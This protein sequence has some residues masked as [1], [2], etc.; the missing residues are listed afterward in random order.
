MNGSNNR[1]PSS[2]VNGATSRN[3]PS[4]STFRTTS[5]PPSSTASNNYSTIVRPNTKQTPQTQINNS[6]NNMNNDPAPT[7]S[8]PTSNYDSFQ[9]VLPPS[10]QQPTIGTTTSAT[11]TTATTTTATSTTAAATVSRSHVNNHNNGNMHRNNNNNN[12][13]SDGRNLNNSSSN[14]NNNNSSSNSN[15]NNN[16]FKALYLLKTNNG[17]PAQVVPGKLYTLDDDPLH[18]LYD[19]QNPAPSNQRQP[20]FN[21]SFQPSN[22]FT[23]I[24]NPATV[25]YA[26]TTQGYIPQSVPMTSNVSSNGVQPFD[27]GN[28]IKRVQQDYLREIQP[29]VSSVK[30]VEKDRE[31]GQGLADVGF[32]TPVTVRKGF[33][34]QADDI[35]RR[36][37]GRQDRARPTMN[38]D[39][40]DD[41]NTYSDT[42][43]D[44]DDISDLHPRN[45]NKKLQKY[46]SKQSFTSVTS[47]S[48]NGID[49]DEIYS[50]ENNGNKKVQGHNQATSPP[51]MNTKNI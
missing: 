50:D 39:D 30:F 36:S 23:T 8:R 6:N 32:T 21:T 17:I 24:S 19:R 43:S 44:D 45:S 15:N 4:F 22:N 48:T 20:P 51:R 37:F 47:T 41:D 27:L 46:D 18:L 38:H 33:T 1:Q 31:Y 29:F 26:N 25:L 42:E 28:L 13:N 10:Q 2:E 5:P 3:E 49:Y 7:R 11:T 35:L 40:D 12:N 34:R 14:S 16:N 9:H